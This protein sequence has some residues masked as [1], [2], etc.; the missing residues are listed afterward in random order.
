MMRET[1][2]YVLKTADMTK[3]HYRQ[4]E[5]AATRMLTFSL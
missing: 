2:D 5:V 4:L 1:G 3:I